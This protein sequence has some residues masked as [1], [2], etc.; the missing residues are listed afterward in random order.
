MQG[1]TIGRSVTNRGTLGIREGKTFPVLNATCCP[2]WVAILGGGS[3]R[4]S[5]SVSSRGPA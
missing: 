2:K 1:V 4:E 5:P 3:Y